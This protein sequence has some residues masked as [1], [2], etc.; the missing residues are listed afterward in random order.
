MLPGDIIGFSGRGFLSDLINVA[1]Y[2]VP[3]Y[4]LS[5]VGIIGEWRDELYLFESTTLDD[6]ECAILGK[7]INGV[8]AHPIERRITNYDGKVWHYPLCR[9]LSQDESLSLSGFLFWALGLPYDNIGAF[10]SGG[11]GF[12]FVESLLRPANLSSIYCSELAA[13][14]H[15]H[16]GRLKTYNVSRFNPN[17]FVRLETRKGIIRRP[18]RLK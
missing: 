5:H 7:R 14:A 2:G 17:R 18:Q 10:R 6:E 3:R 12:S 4:G 11:L 15:H 9:E 13:A 8:Q 1:T 16:I